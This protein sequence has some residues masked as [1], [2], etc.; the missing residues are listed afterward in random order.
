MQYMTVGLKR[1]VSVALL[2]IDDFTG[3]IITGSQLHVYAGRENMT[4]IR[5]ADGYHVF[6][7]LSGSEAEICLEG[8]LYQKQI[9]RLPI[10]Q[11][12]PKVYRVRLLPGSAY[13]LPPGTTIVSGVLAAGSVI[14]LFFPGQKK[15]YKLLQDY[16]PGM[17]GE[18]ISLFQPHEISLSGKTLC[19]HEK[20]RDMEFFRVSDQK[21]N[22]CILEHPLLKAYQKTGISI[23]P[24]YEAAAGADGSF[25][26]PISG[27]T[28][29]ETSICVLTRPGEEKKICEIVLM[30][31]EVNQITEALWKEES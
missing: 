2:P 19:V 4:S 18:E 3:R 13:P 27:L 22:V 21:G 10:G 23:Y 5:K 7:D 17:Q 1:K 11:D 24:V 31:G 15:G 25:Y 14:R 16:D 20:E 30:A 12:E 8:P 6:C 29:E 9:L 26:L 28:R